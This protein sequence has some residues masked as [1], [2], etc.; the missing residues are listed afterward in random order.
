MQKLPYFAKMQTKFS[1]LQLHLFNN[2][3]I[4]AVKYDVPALIF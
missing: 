1:L 3:Y 2:V 4:F